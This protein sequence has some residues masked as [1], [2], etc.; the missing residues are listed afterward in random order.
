M[1]QLVDVVNVVDWNSN[2]SKSPTCKDTSGWFRW[3]LRIHWKVCS[4]IVCRE[5]HSL[6][7]VPADSSPSESFSTRHRMLWRG[8]FWHGFFSLECTSS[9][10]IADYSFP[11]QNL[12]SHVESTFRC[13][14]YFPTQNLLF[15]AESNICKYKLLII[16]R[17]ESDVSFSDVHSHF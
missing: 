1:F 13:R 16:A 8:S 2:M 3:F 10:R 9:Q 15:D 4:T 5:C 12:L 14:S 7:S 6:A 17:N 11:T